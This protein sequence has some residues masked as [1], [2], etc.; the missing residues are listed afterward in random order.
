M[1]NSN[2]Y[3]E[4]EARSLSDEGGLDLGASSGGT[5]F[6]RSSVLSQRPPLIARGV[7]AVKACS[8]RRL[9]SGSGRE[10][11]GEVSGNER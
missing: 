3:Q 10:S 1:C 9:D 11:A 4:G 5:F 7:G 6:F 8:P 2:N